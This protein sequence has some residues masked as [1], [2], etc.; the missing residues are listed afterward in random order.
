[1]SG[2]GKMTH[3]AGIQINGFSAAGRKKTSKFGTGSN[4]GARKNT[5]YQRNL[6]A[7]LW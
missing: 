4:R 7:F 2:S 6:I 5:V 3:L 1:M